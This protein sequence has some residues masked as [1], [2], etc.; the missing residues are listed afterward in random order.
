M[1]GSYTIEDF[2]SRGELP[3]IVVFQPVAS[4]RSTTE[5]NGDDGGMLGAE[6]F[7]SIPYGE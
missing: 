2:P 3:D 4:A 1:P 5:V 7:V 6:G